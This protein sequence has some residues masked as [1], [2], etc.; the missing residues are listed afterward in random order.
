MGAVFIL[1]LLPVVGRPG[2]FIFLGYLNIVSCE[3]CSNGGS[4]LLW[5]RWRFRTLWLVLLLVLLLLLLYLRTVP[6]PVVVVAA[7]I[8]AAAAVAVEEQDATKP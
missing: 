8:A 7:A 6:L 2:V 5:W 1:L 3:K 4:M